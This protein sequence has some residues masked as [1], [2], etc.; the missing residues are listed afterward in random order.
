MSRITLASGL[1]A[2]LLLLSGCFE[3]QK[4]LI[5]TTE[6]RY[7]WVCLKEDISLNPGMNFN[8]DF[9]MT[10]DTTCIVSR[11]MRIRK[12]YGTNKFNNVNKNIEIVEDKLCLN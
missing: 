9:V 3:N 10:M 6:D 5:G 7:D 11:C 1:V 4:Y 2:S 12:T 8:G